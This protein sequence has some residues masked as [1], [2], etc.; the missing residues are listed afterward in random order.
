MDC[1]SISKQ[2]IFEPLLSERTSFTP[3][4]ITSDRTVSTAACGGLQSFSRFHSNRGTMLAFAWRD[5]GKQR[6]PSVRV[7]GITSGI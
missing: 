7:A 2:Q 5:E 1:S 6:K 3:A 4:G